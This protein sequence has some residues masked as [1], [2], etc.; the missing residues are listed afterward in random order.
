MEL[1]NG[2]MGLIEASFVSPLLSVFELTLYGTHGSYYARFGGNDVAE[3]RLAGKPS[4]ILPLNEIEC[5]LKSPVATW[6]DA[7]VNG[8]SDEVYGI[9]AAVDMVKF[10]VAAYESHAQ[11]GARIKIND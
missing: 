7:V 5:P 11:N 1:I 2:G 10:M 6:V 4:Q 3:L 9:D 8:A